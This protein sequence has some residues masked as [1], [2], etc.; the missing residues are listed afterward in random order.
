MTEYDT[1]AEERTDDS[2][3]TDGGT[4]GRGAAEGAEIL[5]DD[6]I[7]PWKGPFPEYDKYGNTTGCSYVRCR[8]CGREALSGRKEFVSPRDGCSF[9]RDDLEESDDEDIVCTD[10]SGDSEIETR[11]QIHSG[12]SITAK[13]KRGSATRDQDEIKIKAKGRNAS[14]AVAE[15][16]QVLENADEWA[17]QLREVQPDG[18]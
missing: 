7:D 9:A 6:N 14:H 17:D 4:T 18:G 10:G 13:L 2:I 11:E 8:D 3:A 12:V 16:D 5:E 1:K 15:M